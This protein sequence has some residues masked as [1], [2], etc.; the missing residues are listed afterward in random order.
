MRWGRSL[1]HVFRPFGAYVFI[2]IGAQ[3]RGCAPGYDVSPL[4]GDRP[5]LKPPHTAVERTPHFVKTAFAATLQQAI[6]HFFWR[7]FQ[8]HFRTGS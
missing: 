3:A 7:S 8:R 5:T 6:T 1:S 2:S 4:W